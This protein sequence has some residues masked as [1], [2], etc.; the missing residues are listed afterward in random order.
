M[1]TKLSLEKAAKENREARAECMRNRLRL[2][3]FITKRWEGSRAMGF[4]HSVVLPVPSLQHD[5][6]SFA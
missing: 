3:Q 1:I 2:G 4:S 5:S 6:C